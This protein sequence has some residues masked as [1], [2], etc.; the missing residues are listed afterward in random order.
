MIDIAQKTDNKI[1]SEILSYKLTWSS[2]LEHLAR[3]LDKQQ[4]EK[5]RVQS[6]NFSAMQSLYFPNGT[7]QERHYNVL[8]YGIQQSIKDFIAH[9]YHNQSITQKEVTIVLQH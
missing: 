2:T 5:V 1:S 9:T 8:T 7:P 3:K 4:R 6:E